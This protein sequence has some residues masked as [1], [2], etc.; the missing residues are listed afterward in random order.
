[1][2]TAHTRG[3][4]ALATFDDPLPGSLPQPAAYD[5]THE[6]LSSY[7]AHEGMST[8]GWANFSKY[9]VSLLKAWYGDAATPDNDFGF[10]WLPRVD[11]DY[12]QLAYFDR[13]AKGGVKGYFL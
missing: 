10:C 9:I 3:T 1:R 4:P 13:M 12:S 8:G 11:A 5:R 2:A 7:I 6:N